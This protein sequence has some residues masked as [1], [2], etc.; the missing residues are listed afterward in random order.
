MKI[1]R[2]EFIISEPAPTPSCH[3]STVEI[4]KDGTVVSA[5]FA[6]EKEG[7]DD[8]GIWLSRKEGAKW[9][10][11][12]KVS[13]EKDIPHWNPVLFSE[14]GKEMTLF[15]KL[16]YK[17][18]EWK[19]FVMKSEDGG[20]TWGKPE[21]LVRGDVSGGRGPVKNKPIKISNGNLIAPASTEQGKW[22]PFVDVYTK[23][24]VWEKKNIPVGEELAEKINVIQP[25]LWE[26]PKGNIHAL[27]RSN[28][29]YIC[30]S[31]SKDFGETWS[32]LELTDIPNNNS[33]IDCVFTENG[34]VVLVCN[35]VA[36]HAGERYPLSVYVSENNGESF[37]RV[38]DIETEKGEF[39]YPA[40]I[41]KGN[42]VYI[43]YTWNRK[44]IV[45]CEAE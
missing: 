40:I 8:V 17:I 10:T 38:M 21:E 24:G 32:E 2:K 28:M 22:R 18:P 29:A 16:G 25:T 14:D 30:K 37:E 35:P 45:F 1:V 12:V 41:S 31:E 27:M 3:A 44:N 13:T 11:P 33:G 9:S 23:E 20:K 7:S 5:W 39:S 36:K 34:K 42:K 4:L 19:T 26:Y 15:Y 6:G 43:T